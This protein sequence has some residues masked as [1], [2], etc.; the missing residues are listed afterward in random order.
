[1]GLE[2]NLSYIFRDYSKIAISLHQQKEIVK[3]E[4]ES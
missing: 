3:M 2:N 4:E 1:M